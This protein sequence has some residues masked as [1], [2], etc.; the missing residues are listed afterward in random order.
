[1]FTPNKMESYS[2]CYM[3]III[4]K[5]YNRRYKKRPRLWWKMQWMSSQVLGECTSQ[6]T[7]YVGQINLLYINSSILHSPTLPTCQPSQ[8]CRCRSVAAW[9]Q[10]S[11]GH[12]NPGALHMAK[13]I[14]SLK[15]IS[16][17]GDQWR[18]LGDDLSGCDKK[19]YVLS[20]YWNTT[21]QSSKIAGLR[22][23]ILVNSCHVKKT[24]KTGWRYVD[25]GTP[26]Q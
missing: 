21:I 6:T 3:P 18:V 4:P 17:V 23:A 20:D 7:I 1:M 26:L 19:S 8:N 11:Q 15:K 2:T 14:C 22:S 9:P 5:S 10:F 16:G 24:T 13:V 25:T 12:S